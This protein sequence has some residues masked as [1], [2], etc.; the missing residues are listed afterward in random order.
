MIDSALNMLLILSLF[1]VF[2]RGARIFLKGNCVFVANLTVASSPE[3]TVVGL[4]AANDRSER[5]KYFL[6]SII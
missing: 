1:I 6:A 5:D 4:E 2:H 3:L